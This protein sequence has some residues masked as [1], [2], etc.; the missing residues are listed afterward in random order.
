MDISKVPARFQVSGELINIFRK[1][2]GKSA[3]GKDTYGGEYV[4]QLMSCDHL[5]NG[6]SKLVPTDL[7]VSKERADAEKF[8]PSVGKVVTLPCTVYVGRQ[9][10]LVV[11][12]A[13]AAASSGKG[14]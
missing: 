6:E 9:G 7:V 3:D 11:A 4:L 8:R 14:V 10:S 12:L 2:E 13:N 5:R 1:P